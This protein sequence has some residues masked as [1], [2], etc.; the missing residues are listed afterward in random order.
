[1]T[2]R[3]SRTLAGS[4]LSIL[5]VA[6][7]VVPGPPSG[8]SSSPAW[9]RA[10]LPGALRAALLRR[11]PRGDVRAD[12]PVSRRTTARCSGS[13][14]PTPAGP[15]PSATWPRAGPSS[16]DGLMYTFKLRRGVK[17]HDGS[18]MT[19]KDVKA[20]YDKIIFPPAG[21]G[22]SRKG[23]YR[24]VE[25][26]EAPDPQTV[27]FRLKWP[28]S[29]FILARRLPV[30]LHLQGGH[31]REGHPLVREE[32]HGD[33]ALR[34]RRAR[35]GLARGRQEEPRLL[36]QGEAL[37]R[38]VPGRVRQLVVGAGRDDPRRA[39]PTSSSAASAPPSATAWCRRSATRSRSRRAR[40]TAS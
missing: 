12:P 31:P 20:S 11:P 17:F 7:L 29:S 40:G 21:V 38:R 18:E 34:V 16:K 10:D 6:A 28:E 36:G 25:V 37:P 2:L 3:R 23:Q 30:E 39:R 26:V 33:R 27:R 5:L 15:S 32:R 9:G 8:R 14:R 24:A 22:S 13:T 1:M 35:Q 19:S 4:I